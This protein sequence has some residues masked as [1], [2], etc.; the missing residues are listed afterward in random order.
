MFRISNVDY[1][2]IPPESSIHFLEVGSESPKVC[3]INKKTNKTKQV[4]MYS[5]RMSY[6]NEKVNYLVLG[7]YSYEKVISN[8]YLY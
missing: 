3:S 4:H 7:L 1:A 6:I 8:I 5:R 2:L